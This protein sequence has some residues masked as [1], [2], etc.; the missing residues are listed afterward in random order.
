MMLRAIGA[1]YSVS[2]KR[3]ISMQGGNPMKLFGRKAKALPSGDMFVSKRPACGL[4]EGGTV[5]GMKCD[6]N[7]DQ[8]VCP[9]RPE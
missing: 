3:D 4:E 7:S 5:R 6:W 9:H 1:D 2:K 8:P